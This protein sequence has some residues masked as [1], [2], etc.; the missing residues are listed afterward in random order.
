MRLFASAA[1]LP[2]RF[3]QTGAAGCT[4]WVQWCYCWKKKKKHYKTTL[5]RLFFLLCSSD[6]ISDNIF[7][8]DAANGLMS[9]IICKLGNMLPD[10]P[11]SQK[12]QSDKLLHFAK[13]TDYQY[14]IWKMPWDV[15][16]QLNWKYVN[17]R[18][19]L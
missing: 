1:H 2:V 6:N 5:G 14:A 9:S 17:R 8:S 16:V 7:N 3:P 12:T 18:S 4:L 10:E 13:C 15:H 19:Q 11:F